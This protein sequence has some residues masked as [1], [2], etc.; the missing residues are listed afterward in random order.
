MK[1]IEHGKLIKS[2]FSVV[3][4]G[5]RSSCI[6]KHEFS[7]WFWGSVAEVGDGVDEEE[8]KIVYK[9][10]EV[11]R[12]LPPPLASFMTSWTQALT[13]E[14]TLASAAMTDTVHLS[15]LTHLLRNN[16]PVSLYT[17]SPRVPLCDWFL[18]WWPVIHFLVSLSVLFTRKPEHLYCIRTLKWW[19]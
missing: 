3:F 18:L 8:R 12:I 1:T 11:D 17:N 10:E 4:V 16:W 2:C 7:Y 14:S 9:R 5:E 19:C 13:C 15:L 6:D